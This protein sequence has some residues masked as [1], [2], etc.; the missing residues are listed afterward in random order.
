[1]PDRPVAEVLART[2]ILRRYVAGPEVTFA[3]QAVAAVRAALD[4][5][6][7]A[8]A[9]LR[10]LI[11]VSST[12]GDV[13]LPA[14]ANAVIDG[15]GVADSLDCFDLN[16]ACVGFLTGLDLAARCV[17]TGLG[18]VAV[19]SSELGSRHIA[20]TDPRP[21]VVFGDAAAAAIVRATP[22]GG[23]AAL[24]ASAFGNHGGARDTV[25]MAHGSLTGRRETIRFGRSNRAI[26]EL[27]LAGLRASSERALAAAG[28]AW[29]AVDH[30]VLHQPNG[31]LLAE[32]LA[33]FAI[34]PGRVV[35][36]VDE[37]GNVG[38]ASAAVGL[39][40]LRRRRTIRA[41]ETILLFGVG[42]GLSHGALVY[43]AG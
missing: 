3:S 17:A 36:I 39:D 34:D 13:N 32:I 42:A 29:D 30:F 21:Y 16:N 33:A 10:R 2:G 8:P 25:T 20:P 19:V 6:G 37:V 12:G 27:A 23:A 4:E 11:F 38:S 31:S 7:M 35:T 5:A 26:G 40:W 14:N 24:L 15:L 18:P 28:L 9:A 22:A 41:G 43:R 1:M